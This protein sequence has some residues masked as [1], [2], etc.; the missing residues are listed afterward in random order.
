MNGAFRLFKQGFTE[1]S[2][3]LPYL[4]VLGT[5]GIAALAVFVWHAIYSWRH[6]GNRWELCVGTHP[7]L[8]FEV[9][10]AC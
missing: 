5:L 2:G 3:L 6:C 4:L 8:N 1:R 7:C 10:I 9:E